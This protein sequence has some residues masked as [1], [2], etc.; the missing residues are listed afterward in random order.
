MSQNTL[1]EDEVTV[2]T[3]R[4][5]PLTRRK[6]Q[7]H[8]VVIIENDDRHTFQYVVEVLQ[9]V[10]GHSEQ[11][12]F[13]L[14]LE[15]HNTGRAV[16][17]TGAREVAELKRDQIRGYGTDDYARKPVTFPLGVYIEPLPID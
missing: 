10:C 3:S 9:R 12:A 8:Y 15:A 14:T 11:R 1:A 13:H 7:P 5:A 2:T 17:W 16:V 6:R 4:P